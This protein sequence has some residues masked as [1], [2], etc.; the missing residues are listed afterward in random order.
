M[1]IFFFSLSHSKQPE[2]ICFVMM[3]YCIALDQTQK[4]T[5]SVFTRN[6]L[7]VLRAHSPS[8]YIHFPYLRSVLFWTSHRSKLLGGQSEFSVC[9]LSLASPFLE[10]RE[11]RGM[12]CNVEDRTDTRPTVMVF[13]L[14]YVN[15]SAHTTP[16][17]V[18]Q[19]RQHFFE[20]P[21]EATICYSIVGFIYPLQ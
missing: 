5:V 19:L 9:Y 8:V 20:E 6:W 1:S 12:S 14:A 11:G 13:I 2:G 21:T 18:S 15:H 4:K 10:E 3:M 16:S 7:V 17:I